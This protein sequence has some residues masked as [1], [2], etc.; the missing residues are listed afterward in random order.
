M[1]VM[2]KTILGILSALFIPTIVIIYTI[3]H[4]YIERRNF[5]LEN[6]RQFVMRLDT[7]IRHKLEKIDDTTIS[8]IY[9]NKRY[10]Y[11]VI[12][13]PSRHFQFFHNHTIKHEVRE[14]LILEKMTDEQPPN[15]AYMSED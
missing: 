12:R 14:Y 6:N 10:K 8:L 1:A 3:I 11:K 5:R 4:S 13:M 9:N 15:Y 2:D 7:A